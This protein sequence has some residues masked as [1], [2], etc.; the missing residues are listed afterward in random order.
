MMKPC[1]KCGASK[2]FSEFSRM[3]RGK[4]G[5]H[6]YCKACIAAAAKE[7]YW[8]DPQR[9]RDLR[10]EM[11]EK[12][13]ARKADYQVRYYQA[14]REEAQEKAR[15]QAKRRDPD[16]E[17]ERKKAAHRALP[18]EERR[19]IYQRGLEAR[20]RWIAANKDRLAA[21]KQKR[22]AQVRGAATV[23]MVNRAT[24]IERDGRACW[25][26]GRELKRGQI[27]LDHVVPVSHG[28][29]HTPDNLRVA[30]RSCNCQKHD[31]TPYEWF[32]TDPQAG[33]RWSE[34]RSAEIL[35]DAYEPASERAG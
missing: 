31:R 33:N 29:P 18:I 5:L 17:R 16:K 11:S 12:Y 14:H 22:Y 34:L 10:R 25:Y 8:Q 35:L 15:E 27:T 19:A 30:C 2:E 9:F 24:I 13:Q 23:V 32:A 20:R 7:R 6:P 1:T 4:Y 28:G 21:L 3:T 26:C